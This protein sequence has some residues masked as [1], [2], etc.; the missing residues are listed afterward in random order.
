MS[1]ENDHIHFFDTIIIKSIKKQSKIIMDYFFKTF[2]FFIFCITFNSC[3]QGKKP[4]Q[5][6]EVTAFVHV[7]VLT[8]HDSIPLMDQ[9]VIVKDDAVAEIGPSSAVSIP[10]NALTIDGNYQKYVTP[11]LVD[12]HVHLHRSKAKEWV[13][14]FVS[15]GVTTVFNLKGNKKTLG[16]KEKVRKR[17]LLAPDI[18]TTGPFIGTT[19]KQLDKVTKKDMETAVLSQKRAGYDM[20]KIHGNMTLEVYQHLFLIFLTEKQTLFFHFFLLQ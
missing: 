15:N 17:E 19:S 14:Y 13:T 6:H 1:Y 18:Y 20:M 11:G 8:M 4:L 7:N 3:A 12:A 5:P 9:T 2:S 10:E 16:L